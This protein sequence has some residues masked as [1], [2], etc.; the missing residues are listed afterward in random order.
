[1]GYAVEL[2]FDEDSEKIIK[3]IWQVLYEKNVSK[4]MYES[5]SRPHI[6]LAVYNDSLT[7]LITFQK[8]V[9]TFASGLR[10]FELNLSHIGIFNTDEGV[11]FLGPKVSEGLLLIHKRFH[12]AMKAYEEYVWP[13]YQPNLWEPH[14]TLAIDLSKPDVLKCIEIMSKDFK[15]MIVR[16]EKVGLIKFKPIEYLSEW[17]I[18]GGTGNESIK[19]TS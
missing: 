3:D 1:M 16:I 7:D 5:N 9:E 12:E 6:T 8:Y 13:Y 10:L 2:Y 18:E 14:C 19:P 4:F 11:V 17:E 15:P